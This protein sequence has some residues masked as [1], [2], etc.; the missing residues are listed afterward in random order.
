M[1]THFF[2]KT[3]PKKQVNWSEFPL[4]PDVSRNNTPTENN[5]V[6]LKSNSALKSNKGNNLLKRVFPSIKWLQRDN[7]IN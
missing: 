3:N 2:K 6:D 1:Y 5:F 7:Y 4:G